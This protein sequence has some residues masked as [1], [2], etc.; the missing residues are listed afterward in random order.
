MATIN[1]ILNNETVEITQKEQI[2]VEQ[3]GNCIECGDQPSTIECIECKD[4]YCQVCFSYQHRKG[5]RRFHKVLNLGSVENTPDTKI[6]VNDA[7]DHEEFKGIIG[8][9]AEEFMS[10]LPQIESPTNL[11]EK[12]KF[13]PLRLNESERKLLKLLEASLSVSNY[14]DKVDILS[15][16]RKTSRIILQIKELLGI[17]A[18]LVLSNDYKQ[19]QLLFET[20]E[21]K[22]NQEF[23]KKVFEVGRRH[24]IMNPEKMRDG[25]GKL[26]YM[27]QDSLI[28][29]VQEVLGFGLVDPIITVHSTLKQFGKLDLLEDQLIGLATM[30]IQGGRKRKDIEH[31]IK[32]KEKAIEILAKRY[33][34][35][36]FSSDQV[37]QCLY[38][39]GDNNAFLR[40]NRD[41]CQIMIGISIN[42]TIETIL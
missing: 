11:V 19:G 7:Q 8:I 33:S 16:S 41:P 5:N 2:R 14:T 25:Y 27:L 37:R 30:E 39:I 42:R 13:I 20:K 22:D 32:K 23:F 12:S 1:S 21:F 28:D 24:K 17:L 38:S 18:G 4:L 3:E 26:I 29:E 36:D 40:V 10:Q 9:T 34:S 35:H 6:K 31:D 15:Y